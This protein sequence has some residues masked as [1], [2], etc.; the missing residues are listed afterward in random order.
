MF[1]VVVHISYSIQMIC[2]L[3]FIIALHR[4]T[5]VKTKFVTHTHVQAHLQAHPH[6]YTNMNRHIFTLIIYNY[7]VYLAPNTLCMYI[8]MKS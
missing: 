5:A 7:L 1:C 2:H 4:V 8:L 3:T 6:R